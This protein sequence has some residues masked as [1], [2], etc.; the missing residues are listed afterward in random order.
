MAG[1][2]RTSDIRKEY[3]VVEGLTSSTTKQT[4]KRFLEVHEES[5]LTERLE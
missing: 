1:G 4:K 3:P 5:Y 2:I